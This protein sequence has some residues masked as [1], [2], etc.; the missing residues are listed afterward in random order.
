MNV[1]N[2]HKIIENLKL[3]ID[4][5]EKL[6]KEEQTDN[7]RKTLGKFLDDSEELIQEAP[8]DEIL[9]EYEKNKTRIT[10][11]K[12][13]ALSIYHIFNSSK[14]VRVLASN[15]IRH[16]LLAKIKRKNFYYY[17]VQAFQH[18][19][20]NKYDFNVPINIDIVVYNQIKN[21]DMDFL[22]DIYGYGLFMDEEYA[23]EI[24]IGLKNVSK[25]ILF[26]EISLSLR[27]QAFANLLKFKT[28]SKTFQNSY[29]FGIGQ[30]VQ[31]KQRFEKISINGFFY[32]P[33]ELI[34]QE[35][36]NTKLD[37]YRILNN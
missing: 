3:L 8:D 19:Y 13:K 6:L 21:S 10:F 30:K 14:D 20:R 27:E 35:T 1:F 11:E 7:A 18:L 25:I 4:L 16:I 31:T 23:N 32:S 33:S 26:K 12:N 34:E 29:K 9:T 37:I 15:V 24:T 5:N 2:Q 22:T 17:C 36:N 28:D